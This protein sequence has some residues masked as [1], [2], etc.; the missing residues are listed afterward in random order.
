[1][2]AIGL[3]KKP[4]IGSTP[5]IA[6]PKTEVI[7]KTKNTGRTNVFIIN[8][9]P[10][11]ISLIEALIPT[12]DIITPMIPL[13]EANKIGIPSLLPIHLPKRTEIKVK[14][15]TNQPMPVILPKTIMF[16]FMIYN[17]L[18]LFFKNENQDKSN[19]LK[20]S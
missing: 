18:I 5:P 20:N 10:F 16:F 4:P 1:M 8:Y 9:F 17:S 19:I 12:K 7:N 14:I 11:K 6:P 13:T 2:W 15:T 3:W